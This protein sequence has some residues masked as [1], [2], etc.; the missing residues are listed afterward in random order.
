MGR[1]RGARGRLPP[2]G[3]RTPPGRRAAGAFPGAGRGTRARRA[4]LG[5]CARRGLAWPAAAPRCLPLPGAPWPCAALG[6]ADR[7]RP[8]ARSLA[9]SG[10]AAAAGG[11]GARSCAGSAGNW[12]PVGNICIARPRPAR[13]HP[14]GGTRPAPAPPP[15]HLSAGWAGTPA[16]WTTQARGGRPV[17]RA[18]A[19]TLQAAP[20]P[21]PGFV[22]PWIHRAHC[23]WCLPGLST[24]WREGG[25][26]G[27]Q[28]ACAHLRA[29]AA[30]LLRT[31]CRQLLAPRGN[32]AAQGAGLPR[33]L[34]R[35]RC[36]P[37]DGWAR[38]TA[39]AS[40]PG[41]LSSSP[42]SLLGA[43]IQGLPVIP[44]PAALF[45][46]SSPVDHPF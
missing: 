32:P 4:R 13:P 17:P 31:R 20:P 25:R 26:A 35:W 43:A 2:G 40:S 33:P 46:A 9:R 37:W 1:L 29:A 36:S 3:L 11:T 18:R 8:L 16:R 42:A 19:P 44:Q 12:P 21:R 15:L 6:D 38:W 39:A 45:Q 22:S 27:E 10:L 24:P 14:R 7:G 28:R 41:R 30:S 23:A 5:R 34:S